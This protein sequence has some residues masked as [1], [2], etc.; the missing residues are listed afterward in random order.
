[1]Q[2]EVAKTEIPKIVE[3]KQEENKK[4]ETHKCSGSNHGVG[5]GN[6]QNGLIL[7]LKQLVIINL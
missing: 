6:S 4:T 1:M 2:K 5:V 3:P 7:N